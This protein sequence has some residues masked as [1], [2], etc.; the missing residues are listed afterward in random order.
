MYFWFPIDE[1]GIQQDAEKGED[2]SMQDDSTDVSD[3]ERLGECMYLNV[4]LFPKTLTST[5]IITRNIHLYK[6]AE[7]CSF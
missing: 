4:Y 5:S 6:P 1:H 7:W 2:D 3:K